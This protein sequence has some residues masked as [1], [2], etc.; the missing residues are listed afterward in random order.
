MKYLDIKITGHEFIRA[1]ENAG[2]KEAKHPDYKGDG[3]AVWVRQSK[4][5]ETPQPQPIKV[6]A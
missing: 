4:P 2:K 5:K 3:V 1:F 6:E